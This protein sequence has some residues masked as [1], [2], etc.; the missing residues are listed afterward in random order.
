MRAGAGTTDSTTIE[1]RRLDSATAAAIAVRTICANTAYKSTTVGEGVYQFTRVYRPKWATI[2]GWVLTIGLLGAGYWL[3]LIKRTDACTMWVSEDRATT[4]VIL[5]GGLLHD[6]HDLLCSAFDEVECTAAP[7]SDF[8]QSERGESDDLLP[9]RAFRSLPV[10]TPVEIDLVALERDEIDRVEIDHRVPDRSP[11]QRRAPVLDL[12]E[13]HFETGEHVRVMG[14][15]YVGRDPMHRDASGTVV[16]WL[17]VG[18][19]NGTVSRTHFAMGAN[20]AGLWVEDLYSTNGTAVGVDAGSARR[21]R[22]L[23]RI[24]VSAGEKI[25]FGD[26]SALVLSDDDRAAASVSLSSPS[27]RV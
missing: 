5:A 3:L 22:P 11:T 23:E 24:A 18:D 4:R 20:L 14:I 25:F 1:L 10:V 9:L 27:A 16:E 19:P 21:L 17:A 6:V 2:S 12:P 8:N 26:A 7:S 13:V 15:V